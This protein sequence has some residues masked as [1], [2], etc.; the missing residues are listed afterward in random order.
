L[1]LKT[2]APRKLVIEWRYK[3]ALSFYGQMDAVGLA[4]SDEFP[5]WRRSG[6][7]LELR[8]KVLHRR[9]FLSYNR[10]FVESYGPEDTDREFT[11]WAKV[12]TVV[13][14][15]LALDN[16]TRLGIRQWFALTFGHGFESMVSRLHKR[17]Y[18]ND[19]QI[20]RIY[21]GKVKDLAY[22]ID[23]E[24]DDG[25]ECHLNVG[26][27][28]RKQ[29]FELVHYERGI[30]QDPGEGTHTF[31]SFRDS[32]PETLLYVDLDYYSQEVSAS[33]FADRVREG[34]RRAT[35]TLRHCIDYYRG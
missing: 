29:W 3:P 14:D 12:H 20:K 21:G 22:V 10:S 2:S 27:M 33:E 31:D 1:A 7:T 35:A 30:F 13:C 5:D 34:H 24:A 28:K 32:L 26:P 25:W 16:Y 15:K 8:N 18:V 11:F 23:V 19:D 17:F 4:L 6:L 9:L